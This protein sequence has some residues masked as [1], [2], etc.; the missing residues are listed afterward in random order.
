MAAA[1]LAEIAEMVCEQADD[2]TDYHSTAP[3]PVLSWTRET[4]TY[5]TLAWAQPGECGGEPWQADRS[6]FGPWKNS[7]RDR[8]AQVAETWGGDLEIFKAMVRR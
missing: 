7:A 2:D 3:V 6:S 5:R 8:V 1:R 4:E